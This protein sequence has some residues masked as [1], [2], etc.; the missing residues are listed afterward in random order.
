MQFEYIDP[1]HRVNA[2][3]YIKHHLVQAMTRCGGQDAFQH[4]WLDNVDAN[5]IRSFGNLELL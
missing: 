4:D 5:I 1:I 2:M 3:Q